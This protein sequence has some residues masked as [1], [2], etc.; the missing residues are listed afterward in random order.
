[1]HPQVF[2]AQLYKKQQGQQMHETMEE[3]MNKQM[4]TMI[5]MNHQVNSHFPK[6]SPK[7]DTSLLGNCV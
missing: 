3:M 6:I 7:K 4:I 5:M 2:L 1:M